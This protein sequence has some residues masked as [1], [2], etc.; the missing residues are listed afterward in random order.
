MPGISGTRQRQRR[1][2]LSP[3]FE[4]LKQGRKERKKKNLSV[5]GICSN[6]TTATLDGGKGRTQ[7]DISE[8]DLTNTL[9]FPPKKN[10]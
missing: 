5:S 1:C 10:I 8:R 3:S 4:P 2:L 6:W 9:N 7:I